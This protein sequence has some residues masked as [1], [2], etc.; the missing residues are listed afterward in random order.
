M[1][2]QELGML[3]PQLSAGMHIHLSQEDTLQVVGTL[4]QSGVAVLLGEGRLHLQEEENRKHRLV[5]DTPGYWVLG[6]VELLP[7]DTHHPW[8]EV[9]ALLLLVG[10]PFPEH[11]L[12]GNGRP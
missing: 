9:E 8:V 4:G 6:M 3:L 10:T 2:A 7:A 5:E 11:L 12:R 1:V